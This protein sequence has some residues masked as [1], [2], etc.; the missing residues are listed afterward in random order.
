MVLD[1]IQVPDGGSRKITV[2]LLA[3]VHEFG[4]RN[5]LFITI[6]KYCKIFDILCCLFV[7]IS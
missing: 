6:V 1:R 7:Y 5:C 3:G 2:M 4:D